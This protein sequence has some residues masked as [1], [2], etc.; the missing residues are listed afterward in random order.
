MQINR[1][2]YV[3]YIDFTEIIITF[4]LLQ[5][6]YQYKDREINQRLITINVKMY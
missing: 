5:L 1:Y 3:F 6:L 4:A 2:F